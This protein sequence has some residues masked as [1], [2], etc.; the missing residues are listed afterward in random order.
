MMFY[1]KT[2]KWPVVFFLQEVSDGRIP[3]YELEYLKKHLSLLSLVQSQ[4]HKLN[5]RGRTA[6]SACARSILRKRLPAPS[7]HP[8]SCGTASAVV[9]LGY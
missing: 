6:T 1:N 2:Y 8:G 3:K 4:D 7:R 9:K 5:V